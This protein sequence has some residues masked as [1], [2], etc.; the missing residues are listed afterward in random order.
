MKIRLS[1]AFRLIAAWLT[2]SA[3]ALELVAAFFE[4]LGD[5]S[6]SLEVAVIATVIALRGRWSWVCCGLV[7]AVIFSLESGPEETLE[8]PS[9]SG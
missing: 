9:L 2:G 7:A 6:I 8:V 1:G 5:P 3:E 4:H